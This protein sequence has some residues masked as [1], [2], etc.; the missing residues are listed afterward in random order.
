MDC[1]RCTLNG[2]VK[3]PMQVATNQQWPVLWVGQAP[4]KIESYTRIPFTGPAGRMLWS[5]MQ[6]VGIHKRRQHITN[7]V[8]CPPPNDRVPSALEIE[9]CFSHLY[10]EIQSIRPELIVALGEVA[11]RLLTGITL[12]MLKMQGQ[13]FDLHGRFNFDCKVLCMFHPSFLLRARQWIPVAIKHMERV[14]EVFTGT[15]EVETPQPSILV[16][17]FNIAEILESYSKTPT[18][19]DVETPGTLNFRTLSKLTS[20]AFCRSPSEVV[21]CSD[22]RHPAVASYL[23]DPSAPKIM[24]NAQFDIGCIET[25]FGE[26]NGL[27]FDTLLAARIIM[28]D[29][30]ANLEILRG[31]YVPNVK[32]YKTDFRT[33]TPE[34]CAYCNAM[35]A[36]V[37]YLVYR[38]QQEEMD[39]DDWWVLK[40]IDMPLI[41]VVIA[42][43]RKGVKVDVDTLNKLEN[44]IAPKLE[45]M[46]SETFAP[47]GINPSSPIQL[48]R[49][50][51]VSGTSE[52]ELKAVLRRKHPDADF[53]KTL[54]E[55]RRL[56]K[57]S[58]TY[59][60]GIRNRLE[61]GCYIH[62]TYNIAGTGTGGR[63][64]S[65][66]PNLQ[67]V[68]NDMRVIFVPEA[69]KVFVGADYNQLELRV[70]AVVS[71]EKTAIREMWE[72]GKSIHHQ[73]GVV[74]YGKSW[75]QLT[76]LQ[77][78]LTKGVVFGT[79]YGRSA[80]S[81][82]TEFEVTVALAERWQELCFR[83]YE[84]FKRY[85]DKMLR[86]VPG[87]I[88]TMFGRK[89]VVDT[90]TK[91]L[92]TP[93][94]SCA[95]D[96][97]KTSLIELHRLGLDLRL[98]THDDVVA[99][100]D[101]N[102][103]EEVRRLLKET[104]ER[105]IEKMHNFCFPVKVKSGRNWR[106]LE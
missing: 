59:L 34:E 8:M 100:V 44:E 62:T 22:T 37:T 39:K 16:N 1:E 76:P 70:L 40:N 81:L 61:D 89:R 19:I 87:R 42:M 65:T 32:P 26:F 72:E 79:V 31:R 28:S 104:M 55:F 52:K 36:F 35:D 50:L 56:T 86:S 96:I 88:V 41:P 54:L 14:V 53:I 7:V 84:G 66:N 45:K 3:V 91:A 85:R 101:E 90:V 63:M 25:V 68:P 43:E 18:A 99:Q 94:Q 103:V 11:T 13:F 49:F 5:L 106:D 2:L 27:V 83:R 12:P 21:V 47:V 98:T 69:G 60:A 75:D 74:L 46:M 38:K 17:P 29:V 51:K 82:A 73:M 10:D 67:N 9:C 71:D 6:H 102:D 105:P 58:R 93:I 80:R 15:V 48:R 30:P 95:G 57:E 64:S 33:W 24:Q 23:A 77:Q 97:M 4:G 20:I 92:N 78:R